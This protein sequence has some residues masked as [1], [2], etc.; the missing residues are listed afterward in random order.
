MRTHARGE[1]DCLSQVCL[2]PAFRPSQEKEDM[3]DR[4]PTKP[5]VKLLTEEIG[6]AE[7]DAWRAAFILKAASHGWTNARIA[8][9]LGISRERVG[10][11]RARLRKL[12][13]SCDNDLLLR[14]VDAADAATAQARVTDHVAFNVAAWQDLN[15]ASRM[16][17][18]VG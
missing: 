6:L 17:E 2:T 15:Y 3:K 13:D 5:L 7:H 4:F 14:V 10:Q 9:Q 12:A 11:R 8:R 18:T 1:L 16:V